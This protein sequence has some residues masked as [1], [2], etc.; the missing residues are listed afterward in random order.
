MLEES[1]ADLLSKNH[2][3]VLDIVQQTLDR[4]TA[5]KEFVIRL[6]V[7]MEESSIKWKEFLSAH[8]NLILQLSQ[9]DAKLTQ[10]QHLDGTGDDE[11]QDNKVKLEKL[12]VWIFSRPNCPVFMFQSIIKYFLRL[13]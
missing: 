3:P 10:L 9:L 2:I 11:S 6:N 8:G 5:L 4:Y 12:L 7:K 1:Y 13:W